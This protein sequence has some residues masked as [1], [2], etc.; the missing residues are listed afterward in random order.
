MSAAVPPPA[1]PAMSID[2]VIARL[3]AIGAA[4]PASDGLACFNRMYLEVT[5]PRSGR[6]QGLLR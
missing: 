6:R 2:D 3:G 1:P 5:N 4:L